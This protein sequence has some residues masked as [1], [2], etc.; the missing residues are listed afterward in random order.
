MPTWEK[1]NIAVQVLLTMVMIVLVL[2]M[3]F[4]FVYILAV[5]FSSDQDVARNSLIIFP[6]H[7]TLDAF[8]WVLSSGNIVQGLGISTFVTIVGTAVSLFIT[9]TTAY[10]LSRR[11][12]P[13]HTCMLW[14]VLLTLL[15]SP[16]IITKYLVVRQLGML[17]SLWALTIPSAV[18][19][20]NVVVMRQFFL[21]IPQELIDCAKLDGANDLRILASIVLPLSKAVLAAIGL[22]YAV[23]HWNSFFEATIYLNNPDLNP[24]SVVLRLLV[25]QGQRPPEADLGLVMPPEVTIQMAVVVLATLPI[26]LV[27]PFLQK[28]FTKGV[29]T[30]S[31]KG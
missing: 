15:I 25:L 17:D 22:F 12:T 21:G 16:S 23:E 3:L 31:I 19:A 26:L 11:Q 30:G 5:S 29:L 8:R 13:G 4:P 18:S 1:P 14:I 27:Y 9:V 7:P 20:F 28:Y 10:A 24:V 6:A 2:M